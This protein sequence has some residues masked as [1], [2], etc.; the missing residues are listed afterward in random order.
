MVQFRGNGLIILESNFSFDCFKDASA[1]R[2]IVAP[3]ANPSAAC[4]V[5]A[6]LGLAGALPPT[7]RSFYSASRRT[8]RPPLRLEQVNRDLEM[9]VRMGRYWASRPSNLRAFFHESEHG[10]VEVSSLLLALLEVL[11]A[12]EDAQGI[13]QRL[14]VGALLEIAQALERSRDLLLYLTVHCHDVF[15]SGLPK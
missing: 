15:R 4:H 9:R 13:E 1:F 8:S 11:G 10:T 14:I 5:E 3:A 7:A 2:V 12:D 6:P